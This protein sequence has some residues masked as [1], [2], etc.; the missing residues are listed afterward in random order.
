[1][2]EILEISYAPVVISRIPQKIDRIASGKG[3]DFKIPVITA[4]KVMYAEMESDEERAELTESVKAK[5]NDGRGVNLFT[6]ASAVI[7]EKSLSRN[8]TAKAEM[9]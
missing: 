7:G 1:M 3:T 8:P 5:E 4:K 6:L 9:I 2:S